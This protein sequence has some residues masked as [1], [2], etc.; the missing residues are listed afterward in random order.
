MEYHKKLQMAAKASCLYLNGLEMN[1]N[2]LNHK[3]L[4]QKSSLNHQ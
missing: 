2:I 4:V 1:L 3:T